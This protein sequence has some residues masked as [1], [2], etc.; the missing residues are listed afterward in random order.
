MSLTNI[1][2][3]GN[4]DYS[5]QKS[6]TFKISIIKKK[7]KSALSNTCTPK[8]FKK[9]KINKINISY[10]SKTKPIILD[11]GHELW[12]FVPF[13]SHLMTLLSELSKT[14]ASGSLQVHPH[15]SLN[16]V[17]FNPETF[18]KSQVP[19]M[20]K[21]LPAYRSSVSLGRY[22]PKYFI[23]S[24]AMVNGIVSLISLFSHY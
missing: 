22:I 11:S 1:F 24:V 3:T 21:N 5:P 15:S 9:E 12:L 20:V 10:L 8:N 14:K 6:I 16:P 18:P 23:L 2:C 17:H 19:Q 7:K 4:S 13:L